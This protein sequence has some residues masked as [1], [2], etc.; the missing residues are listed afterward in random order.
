MPELIPSR[1]HMKIHA[2]TQPKSIPTGSRSGSALI[3]NWH[4]LD[5]NLIR[6][7]QTVRREINRNLIEHGSHSTPTEYPAWKVI[8][9]GCNLIPNKCQFLSIF[10][11]ATKYM[12]HPILLSCSLSLRHHDPSLGS[13]VEQKNLRAQPGQQRLPTHAICEDGGITLHGGSH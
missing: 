1:S 6:R 4:L 3:P 2:R 10:V 13:I 9:I 11:K 5:F 8:R 12:N 7:D